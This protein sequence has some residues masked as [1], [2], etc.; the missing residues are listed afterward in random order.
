M[1]VGISGKMGTGKTTLARHLAE[2]CG[3]RVVSFAD[4]LR[5]EVSELFEIPVNTLKCQVCKA[6]MVVSVGQRR[7]TIREL[8][9][10]WG[11]LRRETDADYWVRKAIRSVGKG[12]LV[13]VDDVRYFNEAC[14]IRAEMGPLI[15][16]DPY[17]GWVAGVGSEHQS[18]TD[19]DEG[20]AFDW[21]SVPSY[22]SLRELAEQ[23]AFCIDIV[24]AKK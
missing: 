13:F 18:E 17:D 20:F 24:G 4:A 6:N 19:L 2:L 9:Q 5:G 3:G 22:G 21:R 1:I 12:E 7:L 15:R 23:V 16:L 10:W 8:L 14:A 11:A